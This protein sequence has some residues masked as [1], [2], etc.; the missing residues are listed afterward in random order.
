MRTKKIIFLIGLLQLS[1]LIIAQQK[2]DPKHVVLISVDG[3]RPEF[4]L[5]EKWP[6]PNL[7][8]MVKQGVSA[9]GVRGI[10]PSVTYPSHTT[11]ITG[12]FPKDHGI[13]YNSPF[14]ETGQTGRWYWE[15]SLIKT[16]TLWTAVREANQTTASFLWPV[17][18]GATIDFN[19]P[20]YWS[21]ES[22]YGSIKPMRDNENPKGFLNEMEI[23]VLGKLN[24]RTFNGDYLNREDRIGEMA[25]YTLEKYKPNF[26]SIHLFAVDHFQHEQG[27]EGEKVHTSIAAVDRAIGKILEASKRAGLEDS[28]TIIVTGDHGFVDIHSALNPNIW[29][30]EEGLLEDKKERNNWKAIFHT[31]GASAF[32]MVKDK[33]DK[34]TIDAIY[35]KLNNLP[36]NV[37]KLFKIV[38][39]QQLDIIGADP[40]AV[41]ALNPIPGIS[42]SG[43]T[44]GNL[45]TP[46]KGG[47]HG[48]YPDFQQIETGFVAFGSDV[49]K[50]I[51][52]EKMG[53][54]DIA[55]IVSSILNL[56]FT[57][58]EGVLYPGI[59][60]ESK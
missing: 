20:E 25:A 43:N 56:N 10:F 2:K 28:T 46:K 55:P 41:L 51:V 14:E 48:Y 52:I 6:V 32:L 44:S 39:R 50:G 58:L 26:M 34:K 27:R 31:S 11:L 60:K 59:I 53:L 1:I 3:F 35:K 29:L 17:T 12:A 23:E 5:E 16:K 54:E 22:N 37:K 45:I 7:K 15:N 9:R 38:S 49:N 30:V 13:Y 36:A 8:M 47:M 40:N 19:I 4:Y 33:N 42:M 24:D 57:A 21:L 18:V